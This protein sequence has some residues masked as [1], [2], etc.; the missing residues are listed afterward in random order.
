MQTCCFTTAVRG[1]CTEGWWRLSRGARPNLSYEVLVI[2]YY[3]I[4]LA[5]TSLSVTFSPKIKGDQVYVLE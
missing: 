5:L 3:E 4:K 1:I 2:L